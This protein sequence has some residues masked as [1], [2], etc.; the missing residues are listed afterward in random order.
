LE[1][2][3]ETSTWIKRIDLNN[4]VYLGTSSV[5]MITDPADVP[6]WKLPQVSEPHPIEPDTAEPSMVKDLILVVEPSLN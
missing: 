3:V 4:W 2:V 1:V 5:V 6:H